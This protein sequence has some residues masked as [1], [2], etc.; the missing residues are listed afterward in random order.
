MERLMKIVWKIVRLPRWCG[1]AGKRFVV[2]VHSLQVFFYFHKIPNLFYVSSSVCCAI[3][4]QL[5]TLISFFRY[6]YW[7]VLGRAGHERFY[8]ARFSLIIVACTMCIFIYYMRTSVFLNDYVFFFVFMKM[9]YRFFLI[10]SSDQN[11]QI[12][13]T[14]WYSSK[15][16]KNTFI[17]L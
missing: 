11:V 1:L 14:S 2:Y 6:S 10:W 13:L 8:F 3:V 17:L 16:E 12:T 4:K 15:I 9:Q 5:P 7:F